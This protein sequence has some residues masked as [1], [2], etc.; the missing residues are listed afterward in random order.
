MELVPVCVAHDVEDNG[1]LVG[2]QHVSNKLA[3]LYHAVTVSSGMVDYQHHLTQHH[4]HSSI[5]TL[6]FSYLLYITGQFIFTL[7]TASTFSPTD[8]ARYNVS[9][10]KLIVSQYSWRSMLI[11]LYQLNVYLHKYCDSVNNVRPTDIIHQPIKT[12]GDCR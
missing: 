10:T 11:Q 12:P 6:Y 7:G 9:L 2:E 1:V 8:F 3:P 5:I 4:F